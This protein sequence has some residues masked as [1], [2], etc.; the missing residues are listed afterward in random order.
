MLKK[1]RSIDEIL[2]DMTDD[3]RAL[4]GALR[5]LILN[6]TPDLI[7]HVKWNSPS[8]VYAGDD[9][10]TLSLHNPNAVRV[11]LHAGATTKEDKTET[12]SFDDES[13][14]LEWHS[15]IR[16]TVPFRSLSDFTEKSAA[17]GA[18]LTRWLGQFSANEF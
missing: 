15:N 11:V 3:R 7:E 12:A 8:Y 18:V 4:V 5:K 10:I 9:R 6:S 14:L 2:D 17:F 13:G 1:Y 16:A